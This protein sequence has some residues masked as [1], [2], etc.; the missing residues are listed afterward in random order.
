MRGRGSERRVEEVE[1]VRCRES[2]MHAACDNGCTA[3]AVDTEG[4]S[5]LRA[6]STRTI[7]AQAQAQA[8]QNV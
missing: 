8:A 3:D 6:I 1:A 4:V 2:A 7:D 5:R